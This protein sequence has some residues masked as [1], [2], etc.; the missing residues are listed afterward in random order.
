MPNINNLCNCPKIKMRLI[1]DSSNYKKSCCKEAFA[2]CKE[3]VQPAIVVANCKEM[4]PLYIGGLCNNYA[5]HYL[6]PILN[7][8]NSFPSCCKAS[9]FETP[10]QQPLQL[11]LISTIGVDL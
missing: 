6:S 4:P 3:V 9:F 2:N 7:E 5:I 11:V 8:Y 10:L 1:N